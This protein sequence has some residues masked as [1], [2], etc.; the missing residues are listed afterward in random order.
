MTKLRDPRDRRRRDAIIDERALDSMALDDLRELA[1]MVYFL[2]EDEH[3]V[4][5]R[6]C[7]TCD[8]VSLVTG[9]AMGC[10]KWRETSKRLGRIREPYPGPRFLNVNAIAGESGPYREDEGGPQRGVSG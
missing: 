5:N 7:P 1:A 4:S 9:K 3:D 10:T 6:P 2:T 8:P